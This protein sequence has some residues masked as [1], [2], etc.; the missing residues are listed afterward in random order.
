M[1][2]EFSIM[3][4]LGRKAFSIA[5]GGDFR[6]LSSSGLENADYSVAL[7]EGTS[8]DGGI[9]NGAR[10]KS[11][12]I[13]LELETRDNVCDCRARLIS[14]LSPKK[15]GELLVS[16]RDVVRRIAVV[17]RGAR[18]EQQ[19]IYMPVKIKLELLCPDPFFTDPTETVV[20]FRKTVPLLSFPF[21]SIKGCGIS[22]GIWRISDTA[23]INN[24][25]DAEIGIICTITSSGGTVVN[26]SVLLDGVGY[27]KIY[28]QLSDGD[29]ASV[30]TRR[31]SKAVTV[32]GEPRFIF[33]RRSI[34]FQLPPGENTVTI[35][36]DAGLSYLS[37]SFS[38]ALKYNGI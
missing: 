8:L 9:I 17:L 5:R 27:V 34:F 2:N 24:T 1:S 37:A 29:K 31:G 20:S 32:N 7:S 19:N 3:L 14:A 26:P 30:N 38:Y 10:I 23:V 28:T 12:V 36:A 11:R 6:L 33:D 4:S 21:N 22:A 25:G 16:R 15:S 35:S 13:K 18:F